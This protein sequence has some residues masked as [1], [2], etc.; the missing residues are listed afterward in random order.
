MNET[1]S[2][3]KG[4]WAAIPTSWGQGESLD[5]D[6]IDRN[7]DR[8]A[9]IPADGVYTTDSDGE[10]Y[11]IELDD[12]RKLVRRFAQAMS[13][14]SMGVAVGVTWCS[15]RG[16]IDRIR[17]CI[18][19]GIPHV[20]V[21]FPF[22]MP[23]ATENVWRFW[24]DLATAVPEARWIHYNTG[25]SHVVLNGQQYARVASDHPEQMV[26]TKQNVLDF[27]S[28]VDC[29]QATPQ[30]AHMVI[31]HT[32]VP[33]MMAGATGTCSFWVNTMPRWMRQMVD[34]C[35]ERRWDEAMA[36]QKKLLTWEIRHIHPILG[37]GHLLAPVAKARWEL[38]DFLDDDGT[39]AAPYYRLGDDLAN[40]LRAAFK[41]YWGADMA[42]ESA[43]V[44][45]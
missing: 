10:F 4:L 7:V 42:G 22:W 26:G 41:E 12:F 6:R 31:D 18:D 45:P 38:T 2:K 43:R 14:T 40:P 21:A 8:Y 1:A 28:I 27:R 24:D 36:M 35:Q 44:K 19:N 11:A 16:I 34:H 39:T 17:I 30:L 32:V 33:G 20:H 9:A 13:R 25:R 5:L 29:V 15:T 37:K 3:L 23:I